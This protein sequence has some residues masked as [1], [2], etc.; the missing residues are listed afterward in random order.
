MS[1]GQR[2]PPRELCWLCSFCT[3]LKARQLA[4]FIE[5][6]IQHMSNLHIAEQVKVSNPTRHGS[7]AVRRD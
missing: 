6:Q 7:P 2:N 3:H 4:S 5:S 1:S